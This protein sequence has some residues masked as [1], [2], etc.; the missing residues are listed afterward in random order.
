MLEDYTIITF[1]SHI[2]IPLVETTLLM[3]RPQHCSN[4]T[5]LTGLPHLV[6]RGS[7]AW[8]N[9]GVIFPGEASLKPAS[10]ESQAYELNGKN[11]VQWL[12]EKGNFFLGFWSGVSQAFLRRLGDNPS[13]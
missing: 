11:I 12:Q 1:A 5:Y 9:V 8:W 2:G 6:M 10:K 7:N 3:V 4:T 13:S